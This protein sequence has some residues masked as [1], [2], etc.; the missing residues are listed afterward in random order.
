MKKFN[1]SILI[2]SS[3]LVALFTGCSIND[4][5][6]S[7]RSHSLGIKQSAETLKQ[8]IQIGYEHSCVRY[9]D[10]VIQMSSDAE[11]KQKDQDVVTFGGKLEDVEFDYN[12]VFTKMAIR[13]NIDLEFGV[14]FGKIKPK[15]LD[16]L[17]AFSELQNEQ[18]DS[19]FLKLDIGC[20]YKF[21]NETTKHIQSL[22]ASYGVTKFESHEEDDEKLEMKITEFDATTHEICLGYLYGYKLNEKITP[23]LSLFT[24]QIISNRGKSLNSVN[25]N[26]YIPDLGMEGNINVRFGLLNLLGGAGIEQNLKESLK[27]INKYAYFQAGLIFDL[28]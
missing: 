22:Y 28:N 16:I 24:N 8:G 5:D 23:S 13:K 17:Q 27:Y 26:N 6:A 3:L 2:V 9:D 21:S 19:K 1:K 14:G 10:V 25:D 7:S 15:I 18:L 20:K 11:T 4:I 12:R